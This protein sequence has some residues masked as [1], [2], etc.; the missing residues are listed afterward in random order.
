MELDFFLLRFFNDLCVRYSI[1]SFVLRD[2]LKFFYLEFKKEV[3][4]FVRELLV[5]LVLFG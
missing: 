2:I 5:Y 3:V 1:E 4:E